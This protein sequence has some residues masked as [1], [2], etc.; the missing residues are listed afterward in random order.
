MPEFSK[1]RTFLE[2]A[3][4]VVGMCSDGKMDV[5][6]KN[7]LEGLIERMRGGVDEHF[8]YTKAGEGI[9]LFESRKKDSK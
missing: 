9:K 6:T 4:W 5:A 7:A 3:G 1:E 2:N 8:P